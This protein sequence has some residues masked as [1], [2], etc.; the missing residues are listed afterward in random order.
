MPTLDQWPDIIALAAEACLSVPEADYRFPVF[1]WATG[2]L[3]TL[4]CG[5]VQMGGPG[6][7]FVDASG[8]GEF[9]TVCQRTA[10]FTLWLFL[11][12]HQSPATTQLLGQ[13]AARLLSVGL[14]A[15]ATDPLNG[16]GHV[17]QITQIDTPGMMEFGTQ[18]VWAASVPITVPFS[19]E[20]PQ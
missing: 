17:P 8:A 15:A 2:T 1:P 12:D 3:A 19:L 14:A 5:L 6:A 11:G 20:A 13:L 7:T 18:V 10:T 4:P 9:A 16:G